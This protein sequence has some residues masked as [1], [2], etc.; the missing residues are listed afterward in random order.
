M[1]LSLTPG[2]RA[3]TLRDLLQ[4]FGLP[5]SV[6]ASGRRSLSGFLPPE[7]LDA[8][9]SERVGQAV[10]RSLQWADAPGRALVSLDH[11]AYPKA[12]LQ[13]ADPP[14]LLYCVGRL[15]L[16]NRPALAVVGSRNA[17]VQ[18]ARNAQA[19]AQALSDAG[20]TIVSGLALGV[21][22]AA[23]RG[24]LEGR[25]STIAVFGTG[26][27]LVYPP[28]NK[29]LA[30]KIATDGLLISEFA[31]GTPA[32]KQ[33]FPR[34][35]RII[36]GLTFG[37]LVVEAALSSGSLITARAAL[38]QGRDVFAIPGSIHSPV[39]KGCHSLIK[40]GAKLVE[41]A[42][43]VLSELA[44]VHRPDIALTRAPSVSEHTSSAIPLLLQ[45]MGFDP[46]D[47]DSL[48]ARAGLSAQQVGAELTRLELEGRVASLPGG[49]YQR[50]D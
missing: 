7:T 46:I 47:I 39:S 10:S 3:S 41:S 28:A 11:P 49:R 12:L 48:C 26:V 22:A 20:L 50:I 15:E 27:D 31:L 30:E 43:D 23:H 21:D 37:T 38:E 2:L 24:G 25:S 42:D 5:E 40:S 35:N 44:A 8:L 36:S 19:F 32:A 45:Q 17:T 29:H 18:G 14:A 33:N 4:R 1:Q 34:R 16:L 6:V 9:Y 13:T